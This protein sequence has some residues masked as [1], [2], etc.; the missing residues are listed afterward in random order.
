LRHSHIGIFPLAMCA[1]SIHESACVKSLLLRLARVCVLVYTG[2]CLLVAGCQNKMLYFPTK[3]TEAVVLALAKDNRLEPWRDANGKLIG[4]KRQAPHAAARLLVFHGNAGCAIDRAYYADAFGAL[5]GGA[6]WEVFILEYPG[7][8]SRDG[9]PGK[10]SF[11]AAG[12]A[13]VENLLIADKRAIFLLGESIGSGTAAALA[14]AVPDKITGAVIMIP[15]ARLEEVAKARFPWLPVSL[16]LR[17]KFDN[18]AALAA[19][20]GPVAFVIAENDEVVGAEQ[21]R[22]LHEA[23]AGPKKLIVL[24][25]ATHNHFP[26]EPGAQWFRDTSDFVRK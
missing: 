9:S 25:G 14:G 21:G 7:Y 8:G 4:W 26:N 19:Y 12:R 20:R 24:P 6:T 17:D 11:I 18:I 22:K 5:A 3:H 13:A 10:D 15:F 2:L 1:W 23:Y 16:L